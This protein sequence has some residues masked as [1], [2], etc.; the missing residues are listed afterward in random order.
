MTRHGCLTQAIEIIKAYAS[1][2]DGTHMRN[3]LAVN[4]EEVY[5]KLVEL[6]QDADRG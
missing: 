3:D 2:S 6:N 1:G 5:K 4:L